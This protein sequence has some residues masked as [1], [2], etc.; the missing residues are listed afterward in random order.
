MPAVPQAPAKA[1][2]ARHSPF[3]NP[4]PVREDLRSC[5]G[6]DVAHFDAA[7]PASDNPFPTLVSLRAGPGRAVA[8][9]RAK[10]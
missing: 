3:G 7:G 10:H 1:L 6:S 8:M 4:A 5:H 2:D 9:S